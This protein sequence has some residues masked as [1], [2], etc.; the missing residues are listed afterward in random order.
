MNLNGTAKSDLQ[1]QA[2]TQGYIFVISSLNSKLY[3]CLGNIFCMPV[4][5]QSLHT[6][7]AYLKASIDV[8]FFIKGN[9]LTALVGQIKYGTVDQQNETY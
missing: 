3:A 6:F 5:P 4:P 8:S 9:C 2:E 1:T 7:P